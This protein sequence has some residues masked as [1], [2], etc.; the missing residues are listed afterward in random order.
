MRENYADALRSFAAIGEP[1]ADIWL[2]ARKATCLFR[3]ALGEYELDSASVRVEVAREFRP[4]RNAPL[5]DEA[6]S[7]LARGLKRA[8]GKPDA[9]KWLEHNRIY[10]AAHRGSVRLEDL[11]GW[12]PVVEAL[13]REL[14]AS[15][16]QDGALKRASA[17]CAT[18]TDTLG[19]LYL[20]K[21]ELSV[22]ERE[23]AV[24]SARGLFVDAY[25][26]SRSLGVA[27]HL[28]ELTM[29]AEGVTSLRTKER[30]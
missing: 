13:Y 28:V 19:F 20:R 8:T 14:I 6:L 30:P 15:S 27:R 25:K 11:E 17:D 22:K 24:R 4:G 21:A 5:Y 7:N 26:R 3:L 18:V 16:S 1:F 23:E 10:L 29:I 12:I 9:V 2:Y